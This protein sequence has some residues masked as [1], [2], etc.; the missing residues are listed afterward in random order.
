MSAVRNLLLAGGLFMAVMANAQLGVVQAEYFWDTDPGAGNGTA[1]TAS[2]GAFGSTLE[3]IMAQ[4]SALPSLGAHTFNVRVKDE[5][6][7]WGPVFTTVIDIFPA[8]VPSQ[9]INVQAAEY[10]WDTDPGAGNGSTMVAFDGNFSDAIEVIALST[11]TLPVV[12]VHTLGMRVQD[13]QGDWGPVFNVVMDMWSDVTSFPD[14]SVQQAEYFFDND[15]GEG[16]AT[17][18]LA[19][20]GA[21]DSV[22]ESI[23]GG[24]IPPV[25]EGVHVLRMRAQ[26]AQGDWGPVFSVV[27]NMDTTIVDNVEVPTSTQATGL[28]VF[29]N[30]ASNGRS[31]TVDLGGPEQDIV[32]TLMN[33]E[34]RLV[35]EERIAAGTRINVPLNGLAAGI[36][37]LRVQCAGRV[38]QRKLIV[39]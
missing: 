27:V 13:V 8:S 29:P 24:A 17:A 34:G 21:F 36:Y 33:S 32:L 38:E 9:A 28:Q 35:Q 10:F 18:M 14:I 11:S 7:A 16:A 12:G 6:G 19:V 30:P 26:D 2:D 23:K 5:D 39:R 22:I 3:A 37:A 1:M 25:E 15:P 20:D 4:T 31:I